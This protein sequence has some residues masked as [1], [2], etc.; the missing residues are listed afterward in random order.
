MLIGLTAPEVMDREGYFMRPTIV[1]DVTDGNII[2]DEEQ[3]GPILPVIS[4]SDID[5]VIV[6]ANA[7]PYGLGGSVWSKDVE[8]ATDIAGRIE[9]GQIWVNQHLAIGPHIPMAGFKESGLG[10]EQSVEGLAEY[11]QVQVVNVAR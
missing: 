5:D 8:R 7:S 4:F 1:R 2:V 11:T 6:R 9:S 3:F 10:V